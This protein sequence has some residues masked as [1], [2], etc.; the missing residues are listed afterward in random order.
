MF[1]YLVSKKEGIKRDYYFNTKNNTYYD[2]YSYSLLKSDFIKNNFVKKENRIKNFRVTYE[3]INNTIA[4][5]LKK[6]NFTKKK[7]QNEHS[8]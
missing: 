7:R 4:K 8:K 6:K 3:N 2:A 1:N 5:V